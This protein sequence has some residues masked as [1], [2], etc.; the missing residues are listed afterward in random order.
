MA[1]IEVQNRIYDR[2]RRAFLSVL[3]ARLAVTKN[4]LTVLDGDPEWQHLADTVLNHPHRPDEDLCIS[5]DPELWAATLPEA[6]RGGDTTVIVHEGSEA[7]TQ[8]SVGDVMTET[9]AGVAATA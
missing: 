3:M 8:S 4:G 2:E 9:P 7:P 5:D 6:F 1:I